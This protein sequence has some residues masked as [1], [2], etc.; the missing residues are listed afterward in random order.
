MSGA[1]A[2]PAPPTVP[3]A[4]AAAGVPAKKAKT[5]PETTEAYPWVSSHE[6]KKEANP[7]TE[8]DWRMLVY[9][10]MG[11]AVRVILVFGAVF[12][13]YQFLVAREEKRVE[14]TLALVEL[15]ET[16]DYQTA[17]QALRQRLADLN[18]KYSS[19][20]GQNPSATERKVYYDR[21]GLEA[22][23]ADG[24][25]MPLAE[26]QAQFDRVVYFLNRIASCVESDLC[27][28]RVAD[29]YFRDY[30]V[31]FWQYFSAYAARQRRAGTPAFAK[32]IETY[33]A[34]ATEA[35][36]Q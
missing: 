1:K 11:L 27:S 15:W 19:L 24:G 12:S 5:L 7:F 22:M 2:E 14:R 6:V 23:S 20:L 21:I 9:A 18:G 30:T 35:A 33:V 28:R 25:A 10:W 26:F 16:A 31:S 29:D 17:Q 32:P 13:V 34:G 3:A 8:R 4:A 36:A